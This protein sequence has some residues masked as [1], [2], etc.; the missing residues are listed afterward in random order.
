[1]HNYMPVVYSM[2]FQLADPFISSGVCL[3]PEVHH[4]KSKYCIWNDSYAPFRKMP[5]VFIE[6][7]F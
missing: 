7:C 6:K 5:F 1:M 4:M 2:V 3:N